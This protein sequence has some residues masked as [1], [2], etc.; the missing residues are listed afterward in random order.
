MAVMAHTRLLTRADLDALPDDGLRHELIDGQFV[1]TPAPGTTHQIIADSFVEIL[2]PILRGT[3]L[4]VLSSPYD[5]VLGPHV[6]EP[7]VVV[8]PRAGFT[9]KNLPVPPLLVIEVLSP[10]TSHLDRGRK[11][12]IYAEA[13]VAQYWIVDPEVPSIATFKLV[14]GTYR[15]TA[16]ATGD[17]ALSVQQPVPLRLTPADLLDD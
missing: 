6:V 8:A 11:R 15:Q 10:S 12:E 7:D 3:D 17:Q 13:G 4:R 5:V 2:R 14:D 1:M 16:H 9:A